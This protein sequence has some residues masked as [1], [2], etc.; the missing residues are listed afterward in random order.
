[1]F[2][3]YNTYCTS[4]GFYTTLYQHTSDAWCNNDAISG[5]IIF[6]ILREL[7]LPLWM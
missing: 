3:M 4:C 7:I 1:M 6:A 5:L 2:Q